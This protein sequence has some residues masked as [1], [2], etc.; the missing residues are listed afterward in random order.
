MAAETIIYAAR[1]IV[2]M[3]RSRPYAT[4]VAV[5]EGRILGVGSL[6]ELTGWGA[7][8]LD[9]TLRDKVILPG[10]VEGHSHSME[11]TVW[12]HTYVGFHPRRAPDGRDWSGLDSVDTVVARLQE[13]DRAQSDPDTPLLAWG[14]DPIYFG[15]ERMTVADLDRVSTTRPIL[16]MHASFHIM[17]V[18]R[19]IMEMVNIRP[20]MNIEGVVEDANGQPTGEL[21]GPTCRYMVL[22]V[23]GDELWSSVARGSDVW[24]FA[25]SAQIAGVTTA[26]DLHNELT[27]GTVDAFVE[28]TEQALAGL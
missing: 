27:D 26:T 24:Q 15:D 22:K 12:N 1:R 5:R 8:H 3:N 28:A 17:N 19:R 7:H 20:G 9:E 13:A 11:G 4:H 10:F 16:V 6:D 14:F 18:S 2:T 23:V 25:R 21:K